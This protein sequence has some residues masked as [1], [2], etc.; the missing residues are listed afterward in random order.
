MERDDPCVSDRKKAGCCFLDFVFAA[1]DELFPIVVD[2]K[3]RSNE[4][5]VMGDQK[6][7]SKMIKKK[8]VKKESTI[9]SWQQ[10]DTV[11][12]GENKKDGEKRGKK[13]VMRTNNKKI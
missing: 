5:V 3:E 4:T 7:R 8:E 11:G 1:L 10:I 2:R 9:Y 6:K 13:K 12:I